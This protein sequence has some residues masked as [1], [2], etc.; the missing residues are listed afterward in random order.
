AP[1]VVGREDGRAGAEKRQL[2]VVDET[3]GEADRGETGS[4]RADDDRFA[5]GAT[6]DETDRETGSEI[7]EHR[8]IDEARTGGGEAAGGRGIVDFGEDETSARTGGGNFHGVVAGGDAAKRGG[9][10]AG[11]AHVREGAD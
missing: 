5:A 2:R 8:H 10:A 9:I 11:G 1:V 7:L 6:N 4:D 3:A